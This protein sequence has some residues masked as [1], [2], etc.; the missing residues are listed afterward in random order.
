MGYMSEL[1]DRTRH[2]I[3]ASDYHK[4][5]E[6]GIL[7]EQDRVELIEGEIVDMAPI[8]SKHAYV[9]NR[10]SSLFT[11]AAGD[12]YLV[13]TQN[14]IGLDERSEPQ[15]DIALLRPGN[16]MD[17]LPDP[18][19]VLLIVEVASSSG[20]YDRGIKLDLYARHGIPE[21]W[22]LDLTGNELLVCRAPSN[23]Q[24][25]SIEKPVA[26]ACVYPL[27]VPGVEMRLG[28]GKTWS[29]PF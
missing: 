11:L 19:D 2:R 3:T 15:P 25:Q 22:L 27:L 28:V 14:P 26:G 9:V 4:M 24:Y 20:E 5:A 29:V 18:T 16:Y 6:A 7:G 10:L 17:R 1:M 13:S 21:V 23:G 8:G 12:A